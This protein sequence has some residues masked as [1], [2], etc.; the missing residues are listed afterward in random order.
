MVGPVH[1]PSTAEDQPFVSPLKK[2]KERERK[3]RNALVRFVL[4]LL[5]V[6]AGIVLVWAPGILPADVRG[7]IPFFVPTSTVTPSVTPSLLPTQ[8]LTAIPT[9]T[10]TVVPSPTA[11]ATALPTNTSLPTATGTVSVD[12]T[13]TATVAAEFVPVPATLSVT[14]VGG[15]SGQIAYAS[16]RSGLPQI[17]LADLATQSLAQ[18][19]D[20]PEGACQPSWSPDGQKLVFISPC[21]GEDEIYYGAGLYIINADGSELMPI[22]TV[23]G[24]DFDPAWSPDGKSIAFTSLRTGQMEIFI[25]SVDDL[26]S[27]TQLTKSTGSIGSRQPAWAPDGTQIV[28]VVKRLGVYQVWLMNADGTNQKQIVRSGVSFSDY[29]PT[30]SPDG[31]LILFNQRCA[32]KF[33]FPYLMSISAT[34]RSVEQG[35]FLQLNVI[36]IEDVEYSPD[37][38]RLL[39]EGEGGDENNDILYMTVT[40]ANNTRITTDQ[41]LDFDPTWRPYGD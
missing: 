7:I 23:P 41:G 11:T 35:A 26:S 20:M 19:A 37:G 30:W 18:I 16:N 8:T 31:S 4:F 13:M 5:L 24:G 12:P 33:C 22:G 36:S 14:P 38:F 27:I 39:Y 40:G 3:R 32:T 2:Q 34:D 21:K 15:G 17:Y 28:Y 10:S 1:P 6:L 9:S 25:L 29:L